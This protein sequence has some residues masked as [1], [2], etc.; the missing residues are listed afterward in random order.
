MSNYINIVQEPV[1]TTSPQVKLVQPY[2]LKAQTFYEDW[3]FNLVNGKTGLTVYQ[4]G[5]TVSDGTGGKSVVLGDSN[6]VT[7]SN[8]N[9]IVIGNHLT[10]NKENGVAIGQY[11]KPAYPDNITP[12]LLLAIGTSDLDRYNAIMAY[13]SGANHIL[14]IGDNENSFVLIP[15]LHLNNSAEF[16]STRNLLVKS[17]AAAT[18][19]PILTGAKLAAVN[20]GIDS[21]KVAQ[22]ATNTSDISDINGKLVPNTTKINGKALSGDITLDASDVDA[23]PDTTK[24]GA[25]IT[26]TINPTTFVILAQ[27]LDQDGN[28]LGAAKTIDLPL[29]SVVVSGSYDAD[30]KKVVLTLQNGST[31]EFS[32]ADLVSG[33]VP[34]SRTIAGLDLTQ[35]R[36]KADM[37]TA[38]GFSITEVT[39]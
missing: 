28:A 10:Y 6:T 1:S 37:L 15:I 4:K 29:E 2:I 25:G 3:A 14:R 32:V 27:L 30:T 39:I 16:L 35:N 17:D 9:V 13:K 34:D 31:I 12:D 7:G 20:S 24:Y 18:Y 19:E 33:L 38:L 22:I 21:T 8:D 23:L 11:N 36:S 26:F 5:N